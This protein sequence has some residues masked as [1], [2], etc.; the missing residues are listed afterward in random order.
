MS[1]SYIPP[2]PI[3]WEDLVS[4]YAESFNEMT[5]DGKNAQIRITIK[6]IDSFCRLYGITPVISDNL[7]INQIYIIVTKTDTEDCKIGRLMEKNGSGLDFMILNDPDPVPEYVSIERANIYLLDTF[8]AALIE[9]TR[10]S[11]IDKSTQMLIV[12]LAVLDI[13]S[14]F[15]LR[16]KIKQI[17]NI[18]PEVI[19]QPSLLMEME[20]EGGR[21][22]R[23][24]NSSKKTK[25]NRNRKHTKK[26]KT[27]RVKRAKKT[28]RNKT[29][30][31]KMLFRIR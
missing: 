1:S 24:K 10:D 2:P 19:L 20:M 4:S 12:K 3:I 9:R 31:K 27:K 8:I 7:M 18:Q 5:E 14:L 17:F 16:Y 30:R 13:P 15:L 21:G 28:K 22:S 29:K 26:N 6:A 11:T 25:H 23:N